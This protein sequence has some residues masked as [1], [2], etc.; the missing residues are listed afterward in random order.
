[1]YAKANDAGFGWT[2]LSLPQ[3]SVEIILNQIVTGLAMQ[4]RSLHD[5]LEVPEL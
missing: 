5:Q 2:I 3:E 4:Q 1:M